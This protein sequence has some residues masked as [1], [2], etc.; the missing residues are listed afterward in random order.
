MDLKD[1]AEKHGGQ[2]QGLGQGPGWPPPVS[3]HSSL[4]SVEGPLRLQ[5]S[6]VEPPGGGGRLSEG[7]GAWVS[8]AVRGAFPGLSFPALAASRGGV[9]GRR[10]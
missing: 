6:E 4:L 7:S 8:A 10:V 3:G 2:A 5:P 1:A 9:S